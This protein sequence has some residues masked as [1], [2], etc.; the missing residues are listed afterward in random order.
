MG[1]FYKQRHCWIWNIWASRAA[2]KYSLFW[3]ENA[4]RPGKAVSS[5]TVLNRR[6][7]ELLFKAFCPHILKQAK[8]PGLMLYIIMELTQNLINGARGERH[9]FL[10]FFKHA[11]SLQMSNWE[12]CYKSADRIVSL[13]LFFLQVW[14]LLN[15]LAPEPHENRNINFR[16]VTVR[17][18]MVSSCIATSALS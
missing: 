6:W 12:L 5:K 17:H 15:K 2:K 1:P 18:L 7:T 14:L 4:L 16:W 13:L 9:Y 10:F 3:L 11:P 8:R